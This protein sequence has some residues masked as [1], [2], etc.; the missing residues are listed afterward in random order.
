M[1]R[2]AGA[3]RRL[4]FAAVAVGGAT[5]CSLGLDNPGTVNLQP[6]R[7]HA[8]DSQPSGDRETIIVHPARVPVIGSPAYYE[9]V[10]RGE[11]LPP[12][13]SAPLVSR[14]VVRDFPNVR[15]AQDSGSDK[16]AAQAP[17]TTAPVLAASGSA[18]PSVTWQVAPLVPMA[19]AAVQLEST[20][21]P[22]R[23]ASQPPSVPGKNVIA[24]IPFAHQSANLTDA[25]RKELDEVA[26][27][28]TDL[29]L[30]QIEVRAFAAPAGDFES[31]KVALARALVVRSYLLDRGVKARLEVGSFNGEGEHVEI[32]VP[33]TT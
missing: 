21:T 27:R 20:A 8:T 5:A 6:P 19:T 16:A 22:D 30:R 4:V 25:M 32:L 17:A 2:Y 10:E 29:R 24:V 15:G 14:L 33:G 23:P 12:P 28:I 31:R 13:P 1:R 18:A 26:K 7:E 3:L 11:R 9:R